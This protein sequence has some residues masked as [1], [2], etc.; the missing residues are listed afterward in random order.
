MHPHPRPS[1]A[2]RRVSA[3]AALA[4]ACSSQRPPT[5]PDPD[6]A[7]GPTSATAP[8][9][10][11]SATLAAPPRAPILLRGAR[12]MTGA[13]SIHDRADLLIA[14]ETITAI[15]PDLAPPPGAQ[16]ID[17][18]GKVITPGI[19]DTHSHM[20]VYPAPG[21]SAH[22][23]G[24][25]MVA[26]NTAYARAADGYW[27]QDPQL[28]RA[29][30]GGVTVA[31]ILPGSANLFGGRTF[32]VRLVP[33][34]RSAEE[35][36]F[37]GAPEGLKMACGENPKRVYGGKGGPHTRMGNAHGYRDAFQ[38]ASEYRRGLAKHE[39]SLAE[40]EAGKKKDDKGNPIDRPEPPA[41]DFTLET[42]AKVLSGELLVHNHCYRADEM[43]L[44]LDLARTYGFQIRSFHHAVEAYKIADRLA[45]AGTASSIWADWWGFKAEAF[46]GVR[47]N[48]ALLERAGARAII[49]S[50]SAVGIQRLNQ[51]AAKAMHAGRRAGIAITEDQALRWI[52]AH[53]AWALGIDDKTGTLEVGKLA[54]VVVWSGD[55]F[56]VY[57]KAERVF[58]AGE[59]VYHRGVYE[60]RTD[61]ELG[62]RPGDIAGGA[63]EVLP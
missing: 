27:P 1:A 47:E 10:L 61:F 48:A 8:S 20:G 51:E 21:F 53:P 59:L 5:P 36:R 35:A 55:P 14:G 38:K 9:T 7:A 16:V 37:P 39:K 43:L 23:D 3:F 2:L 45:E 30:A 41:R 52:T 25:E 15:G 12:V 11:P 22:S 49:H 6:P 13:G 32:T 56:S 26:P 19:I 29:R 33:W 60:P 4:L 28:E 17:V 34:A 57:T 42:L 63:A 18:A 24:N 46:D 44:M 62:L 50:D 40:W 54:D 31:Q 58:I